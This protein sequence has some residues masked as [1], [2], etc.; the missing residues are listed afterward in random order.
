MIDIKKIAFEAEK[1]L[2][3]KFRIADEICELNTE[4]VLKAFWSNYVSEAMLH[5]TTG[6]GYDDKGRDTLDTVYAQ[7]FGA[8][9]ALVRANFVSG[10]HTISTALFGILR[11]G[12]TMYSVS[13]AP[14]DTLLE[15]IGIYGNPGN[16]S[17]ADFGVKYRQTDLKEDGTPNIEEIEKVLSEDKSVKLVFIQRSRGYTSRS[18]LSLE[19]IGDICKSVKKYGSIP[20]MVDNC[21]GEF[22]RESEPL[23]YGADLIAGSLI[24]NPG[25]GIARTGGYIAGKKELV[26]LCSYRLTSVGIGK[27]CGASLNENRNMFQGFFYAPHTVCQAVKT[28][29]FAAEL[30]RSCGFEV[31][32][33]P[34]E[35]REDII[36]SLVLRDPDLLLSF[37][38]G[39]QHG[40]PIDSY[41]TPEPWAMPGYSDEVVM[42]AGT[43]IQGA[44]IELS[45][46]APMKEPYIAYMQGG[47]TYHS[48]KIALM[49]AL[50]E[51]LNFRNGKNG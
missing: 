34:S 30:F 12:D 11:P 27:E 10:T 51:V 13:G 28:A 5:G 20:V 4:K 47:L 29:L 48:G 37:C 19:T 40:A 8:E 38:K 16:G 21:Y 2:A 32:P 22:V 43:F 49:K 41:V 7:V 18:T 17:L 23:S 31:S 24:K 35:P 42:A 14:Y 3:D 39:I 6:Y 46:D 44:S 25:G 1:R 45:A 15:A 36:Q 26:E 50:E 9:D 33:L